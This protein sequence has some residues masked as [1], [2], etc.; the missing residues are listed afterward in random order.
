VSS[1]AIDTALYGVLDADP[2]LRALMPD[3][4]YFDVARQPATRFVLV[5]LLSAVDTRNSFGATPHDQ[6]TFEQPVYLIKAVAKNSTGS[7]VADAADRIDALLTPEAFDIP[8]Y[9]TVA[10]GRQER[11]RYTEFD[12]ETDARW[13]HHGGQYEI[14]VAPIA[15][16]TRHETP[17][18]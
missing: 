6:R 5:S 7:D 15:T 3:G 4:V 11:F 8:G 17:T 10:I 18:T 13:Q 12:P 1:S 9:V 14:H 2:T 16:G